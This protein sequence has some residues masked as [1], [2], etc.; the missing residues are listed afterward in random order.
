LWTNGEAVE[1]H[2]GMSATLAIAGSP[3]QKVI[4]IDMLNSFEQELITE[5]EN[6]DLIIHNLLVKDYPIILRLID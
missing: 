6:D 4:G 5:T 2:P 3:A 1:D